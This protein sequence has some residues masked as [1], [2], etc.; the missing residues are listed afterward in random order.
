V[1]S[2]TL[3]Q[4]LKAI[5]AGVSP[6][7]VEERDVALVGASFIT[8]VTSHE[9]LELSVD[10]LKPLVAMGKACEK[11]RQEI[12]G[13]ILEVGRKVDAVAQEFIRP[14]SLEIDRIKRLCAVFHAAEEKKR[15]AALEEERRIRLEMEREAEEKRRA[16]A[17]QALRDAEAAK[18]LDEVVKIEAQAEQAAKE[19]ILRAAVAQADLIP[20]APP[21]T[22]VGAKGSGVSAAKNWKY[23]ILDLNLL[24]EKH[25]DLVDIVPRGRAI[26]DRLRAGT[27]TIEGLWCWQETDIRVRA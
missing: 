16:I 6:E 17:A 25:P 21:S 20:M 11:A 26:H 18:S 19:V 3:S 1:N 12:K 4:D 5:T 8:E 27:T 22:I 15:Q 7:A 14:V 10:A 13:P 24:A 2:L 9:Q 23:E